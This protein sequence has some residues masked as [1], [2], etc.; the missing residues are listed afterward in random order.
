MLS[1]AFLR[2]LVSLTA[3]VGVYGQAKILLTNDDGW[4]V[5]NIRA[6]NTALRNAGYNVVLSAPAVDKSVTGSSTAAPKPLG[7]SGCEFSSCPP[8]S[9]ATGSDPNDSHLNY[10]NSFPVNAVRTGLET[11]VSF[12]YGT[13]PDLIVSGPNV[14]NNLGSTEAENSGTIGAASEGAQVSYTT[15]D[16]P[17][18]STTSAEVFAALSTQLIQVL[19][20][21]PFSDSSPT[22]PSNALLN[23]N[24][25]EAT[26]NCTDPNA[27]S[28][29]LTRIDP[30][31][32]STVPDVATCG[33]NRLP[34]ES[35]I[36]KKAGCFA[37]VSVMSASSKKDMD[38]AR[39]G[40]VLDR[41]G[42]FLTCA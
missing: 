34:T 29:V 32:C 5:A 24:Y 9:P 25:P 11:A 38:A 30:A 19:L 40:R 20:A 31:T 16:T 21:F 35:N 28:F 10:V 1:F 18:A 27:F 4:A 22:L 6:Q 23:V 13:G 2:V 12:F 36:I 33:T 14:G 41:L 7:A 42:S 39:Q 3:V 26:G 17:S 37:S 8:F 15:L